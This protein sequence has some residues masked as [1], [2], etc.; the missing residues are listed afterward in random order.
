M[1]AHTHGKS[2]PQR[3]LSAD[4]SGPHPKAVG[5]AYTYLFVA[6]FHTEKTNLPFVR[7]LQTKQQ[8]K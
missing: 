6:V 7:G 3:V 4:L 8:R 5:I 2:N 1:R